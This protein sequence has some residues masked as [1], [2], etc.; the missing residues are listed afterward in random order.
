[1]LNSILTLKYA[2]ALELNSSEPV[3]GLWGLGNDQRA[4]ISVVDRKAAEANL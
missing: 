4:K 2:I 1:M 3:S